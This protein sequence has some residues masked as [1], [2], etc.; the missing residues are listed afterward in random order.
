MIPLKTDKEIEMMKEGGKILSTVM[1][2]LLSHSKEGVVLSDLDKL[3]ES[4][5]RKRG[6]EPSFQKVPGY[7][8]SICACINEVIVHGIPN[9]YVICPG[10][11]VGID[12]G[13]FYKGFNTDMS[14]TIKVKS[15]KSHLRQGFGGQARYIKTTSR[16]KS[17]ICGRISLILDKIY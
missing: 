16:N 7:K 15:Q 5:I 4:E 13:V 2:V 1:D 6:A 14:E 17:Y 3:A 12:C 10:D 9:E 11:I 8:Y